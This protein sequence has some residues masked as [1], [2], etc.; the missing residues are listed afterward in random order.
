[1]EHLFNNHIYCGDWCGVNRTEQ[2]GKIYENPLGFFSKSNDRQANIY[3][4]LN[5]VTEKYGFA[6]YLEQGI[7][8]FNT[9]TN[10][11][12]IT[13]RHALPPRIRFSIQE[14]IFIIDMKS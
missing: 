3:T 5:K 2:N 1:M 9:Q 13:V 11:S 6:F 10:E 12:L 14:S 4:D 7:H 8:V